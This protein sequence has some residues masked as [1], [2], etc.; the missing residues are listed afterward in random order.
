MA[1]EI[2]S[3]TV[4]GYGFDA[5]ADVV[6]IASASDFSP[7]PE[8]FKPADGLEGCLSVVVFGAAS[9]REALLG[10][11]AE[12]TEFRKEMI[13]KINGIAKNV[14]KRIKKDGYKARYIG[15][16]GGKHIDGH[17]FG[18]VSLKHAAEIAGLGVIG[19][20]YLV[21]NPEY[22]TLLWFSGILTDA[23]LVP[24]ERFKDAICENCDKCVEVCPVNALGEHS[25]F[26]KRE[27]GNNAFKLANKKF[28]V[29]CFLCRKVCPY[30][31][32]KY[33]T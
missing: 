21:I 11:N 10:T 3:E 8:G 17:M 19:K 29:E 5:G 18:L 6:G 20:N 12:Y 30:R 22:G 13:E 26:R 2:T 15:G 4:K 9:P 16:F 23:G 14:E 24:D 31:F 28:S 25:S 7:A 27:C 33:S 1:N 32:G